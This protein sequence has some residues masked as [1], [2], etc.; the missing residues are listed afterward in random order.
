MVERLASLAAIPIIR[1][2]TA[3]VILSA[4]VL[5]I[6]KTSDLPYNVYEIFGEHASI[7]EIFLFSVAVIWTGAS[8]VL[9][10]RS[11]TKPTVLNVFISPAVIAGAS[12]ISYFCLAASVTLESL[13]DILGAETWAR[14]IVRQQIYGDA[15]ATLVAAEPCYRLVVW[16]EHAFRFIAVQAPMLF[17]LTWS[18]FLVDSIKRR[19]IDT[20]L[21]W[22]F[23]ITAW[24]CAWIWLCKLVVFDHAVT[25]NIVELVA[26]YS[27]FGLGGELFLFGIVV[28]LGVNA[29]IVRSASFGRLLGVVGAGAATLLCCYLSWRLLRFA[30]V[31]EL[32]RYGHTYSGIDFLLGPNRAQ[33]LDDQILMLRWFIC[34]LGMV[35]VLAAGLWTVPRPTS[36]R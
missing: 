5:I 36:A 16:L 32:S 2:T 23:A 19:N 22:A 34:Y 12:L 17:V 8:A 35:A 3:A 27:L 4:V 7:F 20:R 10:A 11:L 18:I 24:Y 30:A 1:V 25:D 29:V 21:Y 28:V 14:Q 9:C 26:T 15:L 6:L 33:K 13:G 31:G